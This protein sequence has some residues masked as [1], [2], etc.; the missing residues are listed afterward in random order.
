M[1]R[2]IDEEIKEKAF[3]LWRK[4]GQ[5]PT[6]VARVLADQG[7]VITRQTIDAWAND[8]ECDWKGRSARADAVEQEAKDPE[9]SGEERMIA[10]LSRQ[11]K[12]YEEYFETLTVKNM[13]SQAVYA[14]TNLIST[15]QSIRQK[16]DA[17]RAEVFLD[18]LKEL[19]GWLA[20]NDPDSVAAIEK[21]FDDF[22]LYAKERYGKR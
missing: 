4:N 21:N 7:H 11:A 13:D 1:G 20:K 15:L 12:R 19:I 16:T 6:K 8:P 5:S 3:Q 2:S 10:A 9:L 14:Y 22:A 17:F 18:F